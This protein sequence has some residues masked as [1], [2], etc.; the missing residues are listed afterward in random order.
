[1]MTQ[2]QNARPFGAN[3]LG[4]DRKDINQ[5]ISMLSTDTLLIGFARRFAPYKRA[6]LLFADLQRLQNN[7]KSR[8]I[9]LNNRQ[10]QNT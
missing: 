8:E 1:M 3:A 9:M 7:D 2:C 5:A 6:N 4:V 10:R